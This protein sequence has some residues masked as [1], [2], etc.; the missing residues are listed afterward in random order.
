MNWARIPRTT[1]EGEPSPLGPCQACLLDKDPDLLRRLNAAYMGYMAGGCSEPRP[2][3]GRSDE[4]H[5]CIAEHPEVI[6][7]LQKYTF[8]A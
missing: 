8:H 7:R 5:N 2:D 6:Q 1:A 3:T 4:L